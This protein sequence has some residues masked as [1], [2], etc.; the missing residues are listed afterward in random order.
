MLVKDVTDFDIKNNIPLVCSVKPRQQVAPIFIS[1]PCTV[2]SYEQMSI[3]ASR[4]KQ[5]GI[6]YMRGGAYK[7][8]TFPYRNKNMYELGEV[9]ANILH[10][11]KM[12][13]NINIV[14]EATDEHSLDVIDQ[15][16]DIIQIG[17]R[18]MY[19]YSLLK[20]AAN[21]NK[22]IL[23][24]RHFGA[25]V[26]DWLGAAEYIL[27]QGNGDVILCERGITAPHTHESSSRFI[28]DI[29]VIPNIKKL[30]NLP[31][32]FDP[33][34]ATFNRAFVPSMSYAAIAAGADGIIMESHP[35]PEQAAVD[36]LNAVEFD[37]V[38]EI[39]NKCENIFQ[40]VK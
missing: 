40:I 30:T 24:K 27:D 19:N 17:S 18:N 13:Q 4:L 3:T 6:N 7:P 32:I 1:G 22:P 2:E 35:T 11:V 29:Q 25:S 33:S 31:I 36:K 38:E 14:T 9:G 15:V 34:H 26:R 16:A 28:S 12:E 5:M 37:M 20:Q 39:K 21:K 23:L 8:L 10:D